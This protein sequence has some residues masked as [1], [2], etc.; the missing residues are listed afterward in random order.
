MTPKYVPVLAKMSFTAAMLDPD[1]HNVIL[2][3]SSGKQ[4]SILVGSISLDSGPAPDH[5]F[6]TEGIIYP[7]DKNGAALL[8]NTNTPALSYIRNQY[9]AMAKKQAETNLM[10]AEM[11]A[12]FAGA[13]AALGHAG[14]ASNYVTAPDIDGNIPTPAETPA[15]EVDSPDG[16]ASGSG[17]N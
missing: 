3:Y 5:Y 15:N 12:S 2:T 10:F 7:I 6:K 11:V 16:Q 4:V 1:R 8:D 13:V 14:E 9:W 17:S